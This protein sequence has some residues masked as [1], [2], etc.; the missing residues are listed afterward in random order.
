[1]D[2]FIDDTSKLTLNQRK[3]Y[4]EELEKEPRIKW[5]DVYSFDINNLSKEEHELLVLESE[6]YQ[7]ARKRHN[8]N[9]YIT[10]KEYF[11]KKKIEYYGNNPEKYNE[12]QRRYRESRPDF[13]K[14]KITCD[15][16]QGTYVMCRL[17]DHLGTAKHI[18]ALKQLKV[19]EPAK[20]IQ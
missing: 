5:S 9:Y 12:Y 20:F 4:V 7:E 8:H 13:F 15:V 6:V 10:H 19:K 18:R 11:L 2:P 3:K 14:D 16:C 1:M 17:K